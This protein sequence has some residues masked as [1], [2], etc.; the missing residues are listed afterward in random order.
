MRK[1]LVKLFPAVIALALVFSIIPLSTFAETAVTDETSLK[2]AVANG[3]EISVSTDINM[4][5]SIDV[6]KDTVIYLNGGNIVLGP[7]YN[8]PYL[9]S[10]SG[11]DLTIIAEGNINNAIRYSGKGSTYLLTG[12]S[13]K[14]TSVTLKNG[15][16]SA[17][18]EWDHEIGDFAY[19]K[20]LFEVVVPSGATVPTITLKDGSFSC[21]ENDPETNYPTGSGDIICGNDAGFK[22]ENGGFFTEIS[23]KYLDSD[24]VCFYGEM[25]GYQVL[26]LDT[27][28]SDKFA[29]ILNEEGNLTVKRFAPADEN[30]KWGLYNSL[31]YKYMDVECN[32]RFNFHID[33]F[34]LAQKT[35][36]ISLIDDNE[37]ILETHKIKLDFVYDEN[38]KTEIDEIVASMPKGEDMGGGYFAPHIFKVNDLELVNYWL[39]CDAETDNTNKLINYS[40]EFK[41]T[42]GYKNFEIDTG[43]GADERFITFAGGDGNFAIDGTVYASTLMEVEGDHIIYV[44]DNTVLTEDAM[45]AAAQKRI[46][47]YL[48][49]GKVVLKSEGTLF[50]LLDRENFAETGQHLDPSIDMEAEIGIEG[51]KSE[52]FVCSTEINGLKYQMIIWRGSDKM[53]MPVYKNVDTKTKITVSSDEAFV[54]LDTLISVEEITK[55]EEYDKIKKAIDVDLTQS[56]DIGLYSSSIKENIKKLES[57]KFTVSIPIS[58]KFDGKDLMV[59]YVDDKGDTIPHVVTIDTANNMAVFETNH[60]SIYTLAAKTSAPSGEGSAE[61]KPT[62]DTQ[63]KSPETG[64]N[65]NMIF[66]ISLAILS[67]TYIFLK[68]KNKVN[69]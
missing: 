48:G 7:G 37:V 65:M 50:E 8:L 59:Y 32:P 19:P 41:N 66:I 13:G 58:E 54:P 57:G 12:V 60:F 38:L 5:S 39:T 33:S 40:D 1:L 18:N 16:H 20:A 62:T 3:G 69:N 67:G 44:S 68:I 35:L 43:Y 6:T 36:Y 42:I 26:K 56:F 47:D 61:N 14:N 24:S 28:V 17:A 23:E 46:D 51:V 63:T 31:Y 34:D 45:V 11:A 64:D 30:G 2:A 55:G 29:S 15:S 9:F 53:V 4:T 10:V 25:N 22:I 52:D 21:E 27:T 49:K